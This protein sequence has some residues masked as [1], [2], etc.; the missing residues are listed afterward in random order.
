MKNR[1]NYMLYFL[2]TIPT[3]ILCI[4]FS[5]LAP[6][7]GPFCLTSFVLFLTFGF[8][9]FVAI[10]SFFFYQLIKSELP[11]FNIRKMF[12]YLIISPIIIYLSL[13]IKP[14]FFSNQFILSL[15]ETIIILFLIIYPL[16]VY[17]TKRDIKSNKNSR[18]IFF[19]V[20]IVI[21]ILLII[22]RT[23]IYYRAL[24]SLKNDDIS[25][26]DT[27]RCV[28]LI[29]NEDGNAMVEK[30]DLKNETFVDTIKLVNRQT[31]I[32]KLY[33]ADRFIDH[34]DEYMYY[35]VRHS[36][37]INVI[38]E[39]HVV[40]LITGKDTIAD[41]FDS[42]DYYAGFLDFSMDEDGNIFYSIELSDDYDIFSFYYY[43]PI[44][45]KKTKEKISQKYEV[46]HLANNGILFYDTAD[47]YYKYNITTNKKSEISY[48]EFSN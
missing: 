25:D 5:F 4:A 22:S 15:Y 14:S 46:F 17:F 24:N 30:K 47:R 23:I 38:E 39:L 35:T 26:I 11:K 20:I 33:V 29:V 45:N 34:S 28:N 13:I 48:E 27:N 31:G 41:V 1:N 37:N 8:V 19:I 42:S 43:D 6:S 36:G 16:I 7:C 44:K 9:L 40:E 32:E 2:K 12:L 3:L 18:K 10:E 21:A